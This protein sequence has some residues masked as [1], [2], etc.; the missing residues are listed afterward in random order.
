MNNTIN[1]FF[2]I[3]LLF[4]F[5]FSNFNNAKEILIY[6]DS[7]SYDEEEN[8]IAKGNAKVFQEN[9][10]I[11]SYLIIVNKIDEK[12]ILPSKFTF[13]DEGDNFFQGENGYFKKS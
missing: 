8:I 1:F 6:A 5:I 7:I 10:L 4:F 12:I 3:I 13:K 11:L 2:V 9:K